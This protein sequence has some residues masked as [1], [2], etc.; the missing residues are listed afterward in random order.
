M[1]YE[2]NDNEPENKQ[3]THALL[4]Q[5]SGE[6]ASLKKLRRGEATRNLFY[7]IFLG[8]LLGFTFYSATLQGNR[9]QELESN[10]IKMKKA[11]KAFDAELFNEIQRM[12][13]LLSGEIPEEL[14]D[15]SAGGNALLVKGTF[16]Q[17]NF[18]SK[19]TLASP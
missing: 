2:S 19:E 16:S 13:D 14:P 9:I 6:L 10:Q 18:F 7:T 5:I 4:Q 17:P 12:D 15:P 8:L 11:M 1:E 3:D